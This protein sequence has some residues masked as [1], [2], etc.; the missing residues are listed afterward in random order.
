MARILEQA[1][2]GYKSENAGVKPMTYEVYSDNVL[3]AKGT[4]TP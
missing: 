1:F 2:N 4:V 3:L